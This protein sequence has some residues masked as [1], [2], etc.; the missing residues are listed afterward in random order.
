M[1]NT[2]NIRKKF[3]KDVLIK[4]IE[5]GY[6]IYLDERQVMTP[7]KQPLIVAYYQLAEKIKQEWESQ[8]DEINPKAMPIFCLMNTIIDRSQEHR[9][10]LQDTLLSYAKSDLLCYRED[11]Q[12][13][14]SRIEEQKWTPILNWISDCFGYRPHITKGLMAIEQPDHLLQAIQEEN[15]K[16]DNYKLSL[17]VEITGLLSS[18]YLAYATYKSYLSPDEIWSLAH[19]AEDW[20]QQKWGIDAEAEALLTNK[21]EAF[22][23]AADLISL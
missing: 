5:D 12:Q 19:I 18:Y 6:G 1:L 20:N 11:G 4:P 15:Q 21:K 3:W 2:V 13:E 9:E 16:L 17:L 7:A 22:L 8:G 14:L 23:I 10:E